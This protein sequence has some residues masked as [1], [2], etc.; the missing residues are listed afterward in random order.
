MKRL[1]RWLFYRCEGVM[2]RVLIIGA[3]PAGL[4]AAYELQKRGREYPVTVLEEADCVGGIIPDSWGYVQ[5]PSVHM[6]RFQICNNMDHAMC[7]AFD[8]A[9][10]VLRGSDDKRALWNA[11]M[12]ETYHESYSSRS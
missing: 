1:S 7:T 5:A 11:N 2:K 4:T 10:A 3:G 12:E 8:A 6:G 9:R